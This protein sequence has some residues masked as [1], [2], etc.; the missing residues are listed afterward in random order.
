M[1]IKKILVVFLLFVTSASIVVA[2]RRAQHKPE[3]ELTDD[4]EEHSEFE[5]LFNVSGFDLIAKA[6]NFLGTPYRYGASSPKGFDCSGF[7]SYIYKCMNI[8]LGRSSR[9]QW[10]QGLSI[11]KDEIQVGDLVFFGSNRH[12]IGHVGIVC[13]VESDGGFKFIH[14]SCGRGVTISDIDEGYYA[15]K[16]RGARRI[17]E[18]YNV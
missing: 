9:D 2:H 8:S 15:R 3:V 17:L 1:N 5:A 13:E 4:D 12:N 18:G 11:D 7:T 6:R 10:K 14:S 16:Y